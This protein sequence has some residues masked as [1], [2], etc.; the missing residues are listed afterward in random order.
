MRTERRV[1]KR[2]SV[3]E[4]KEMASTNDDLELHTQ[5]KIALPRKKDVKY[6]GFIAA[7]DNCMND[8]SRLCSSVDSK[9]A[10]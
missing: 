4:A 1:I 10:C 8:V 5:I 3:T 6:I 2:S 7:V 9:Q